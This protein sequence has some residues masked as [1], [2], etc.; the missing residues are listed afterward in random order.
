M[1]GRVGEDKIAEVRERTS[2]V[3]LVSRYTALKRTGRNH[4]GLCPFHSEKTPSFSVSEERGLFYCFGCQASGDVFKFLMLKDSLTFPEALERLARE[5]GVELPKR[6]AEERRE[7]GRERLLRVNEFAT[8]F[9][10]RALWEAPAGAPAR[11][12]LAER[13]IRED[14]A[15]VFGLGYAPPDGLARAFENVK[16]PLADAESLGLIGKSTRGGGWFDRFRNRLM[17]PITD[18]AGKTIAFGGRLLT[19]VEGQPKYLNSQESP[20]FQKRR[21]VFGLAAARDAINER[22]RVVLVEGYVDV[23]ALAQA[24]IRNVVAPLGTSL[25]SDQVRLLKRFTDEFLVLFDGDRAGLTAAARAFAVFAE[26]GIFAEAALLPEGHDPDTFVLK[27]GAAALEVILGRASPLVDHY[28][29][30]LAAPDG[31][32]GTRARAAQEVAELCERLENPIFTGLLRRRAAEYLGLPE[33]QLRR[34]VAP[35]RAAEAT[36][37]RSTSPVPPA[38]LSSQ[39]LHILELLLVHRELQRLLPPSAEDLFASAEARGL[40]VRIRDGGEPTELVRAL[41]REAADRVARAWL[42]EREAYAAPEQML[43]DCVTR[44]VERS[45][46]ARLRALTQEIREAESRGDAAALRALLAEKLR[47]S[48]AKPRTEPAT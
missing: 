23:I 20:L 9:F 26:V 34:R 36:P 37:V 25:T 5:A 43:D 16:A 6:P 39:E 11:N 12:Y 40:F 35:R 22:R 2:I 44:L 30:S 3:E 33:D 46:E 27:E 48:A 7:Q 17:F 28:L 1:S 42:G 38:S 31:S 24:G 8:K 14:T 32:L 45:R 29:H 15:R 4:Q 21:S 19:A 18:L 10:Q 13:Q 47:L 41:P